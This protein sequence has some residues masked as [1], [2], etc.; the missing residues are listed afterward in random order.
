M[1]VPLQP[2]MQSWAERDVLI[3][4]K[5]CRHLQKKRWVQSQ[6]HFVFMKT[7]EIWMAEVIANRN[8]VFKRT[9]LRYTSWRG[10]KGLLMRAWSITPKF[11][12]GNLQTCGG[13][14]KAAP[15]RNLCVSVTPSRQ[16]HRV[17]CCHLSPHSCGFQLSIQSI[18]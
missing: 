10:S 7:A 4:V 18:L 6:H 1:P 14:F 12:V 16:K 3:L 9:H 8:T 15:F 2:M 11:H 17:Q 5:Q 13:L